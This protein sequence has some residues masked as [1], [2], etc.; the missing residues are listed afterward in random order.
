MALLY[1]MHPL[2]GDGSEGWGDQRRNVNRYLRF[3][4]M[5]ALEGHTVLSWA[6][7]WLTESAGLTPPVTDHDSA[8]WYLKRDLDLI[9]AAEL[10]WQAGPVE[11]S[12][13]IGVELARFTK[14]STEVECREEWL[15]PSFVPLAGGGY[16]PIP[17]DLRR[18]QAEVD[19]WASYNF[20]ADRPS[21][22]RILGVVEEG[23]ELMEALLG[24]LLAGGL[25]KAFGRLSHAELKSQQGIRTNE[26]R[27]AL[28]E[29]AVADID[30]YLADFCTVMG[31]D[32]QA[33]LE[34][35]WSRV[36]ARDWKKDPVSGGES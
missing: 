29:D 36:K 6:W 25:M 19:K 4:S 1:I 28:V 18:F 34:K 16:D 10:G 21:D 27:R 33:V 9:G 24:S 30:V 14:L 31:I 26:D 3:C 20:G 8:M 35:T 7:N 23:G 32:R 12:H 15:D 13:G 22:Q 2:T 11:V 5:A 17:L